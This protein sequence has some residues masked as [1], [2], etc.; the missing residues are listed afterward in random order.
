M[1][2][3]K[4]INSARCTWFNLA[5][6]AKMNANIY[7]TVSAAD[8]VKL[9]IQ[10]SL[11]DEYR[12]CID[13]EI[14]LSREAQAST[15]TG[16][17]NKID[18]L[19]D[20]DI[21]YFWKIT[22]AGLL[23]PVAAQRE[24]SANLEIV[25]RPY[26]NIQ[27]A[28]LEQETLLINGMLHDLDTEKMKECLQI[29]SLTE[30]INDLKKYNDQFNELT[31][32]RSNEKA[33]NKVDNSRIVRPHT[34][35][36]YKRICDLIY[37]SLLITINDADKKMISDLI[38]RINGFID[39]ANTEYNQT[40]SKAKKE[41]D[42]KKTDDSIKPSEN[43]GEIETTVSTANTNTKTEDSILSDTSIKDTKNKKKRKTPYRLY[44]RPADIIDSNGG[45]NEEK[46]E[47][48]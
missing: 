43:P 31:K 37:A 40:R 48:L 24:A 2:A 1:E 42:N 27:N 30:V 8:L 44:K 12:S 45:D 22:K 6:H 14:E 5:L 4:T 3:I 13:Q 16:K 20:A 21:S 38:D 41:T 9:N 25:V 39:K 36:V 15:I 17:L 34:D 10:K 18:P 46:P 47:G 28:T 7:D 35:T 33:A 11:M 23:S 32:Q 29:L 19:R 26:I